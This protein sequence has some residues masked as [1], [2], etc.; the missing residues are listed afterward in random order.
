MNN[1]AS[2]IIDSFDTDILDS[3]SESMLENNFIGRFR[4]CDRFNY[5]L[6]KVGL[7]HKIERNGSAN[8]MSVYLFD[9]GRR[10][11]CISKCPNTFLFADNW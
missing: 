5:W 10:N 2:F 3:M 11:S 7:I 1:L 6:L 9:I 8:K 4:G